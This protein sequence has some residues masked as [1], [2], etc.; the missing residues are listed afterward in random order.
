MKISKYTPP[1]SLLLLI[2]VTVTIYT[3]GSAGPFLFDDF[4]N[5][6]PMA[7]NGGV[8]DVGNGLA[9][10]FGSDGTELLRSV[11]RASF[12]LN[13][14][15]WPSLP[16][17][18]KNTNILLHLI[19]G[20][21]VVYLLLRLLPRHLNEREALV[22][23]LFCGAVWLL[24]PLHVSTV[25]YVVQRMT[26][27]MLMFVL[28]S[29][30]SYTYFRTESHR[31]RKFSWLMI[32]AITALLG[33][34]SKENAAVVLMLYWLVDVCFFRDEKERSS[35]FFR[36][37]P[38]LA[39]ALFVTVFAVMVFRTLSVYDARPF[40]MSERLLAQ[41]KVIADYLYFWFSP[42]SLALSLFHDDVLWKVQ[43]M[44][45]LKAL[46]YWVMHVVIVLGSI[47]LRKRYPIIFFGVTFFYISHVIEST[48]IPLELMFEHR[49]YLPS[50]G[51]ALVS[52]SVVLK[53]AQTIKRHG[54]PLASLV[55][56]MSLLAVLS[57]Y[58]AHR[59]A[60]WSDYRIMSSKWAA[61]HPHSLRA[62]IS[63]IS[64]LEL[65]RMGP[66]AADT[67][68]MVAP[69]FE[70]LA[71]PMYRLRLECEY[72]PPTERSVQVNVTEVSSMMFDSGV[73]HQLNALMGYPEKECIESQLVNGGVS[74]LVDA[75]GN[76][77][78]LAEK[79]SYYAQYLDAAADFYI[80]QRNYVKAIQLRE[81]LWL[82][83]PSVATALQFSELFILGGNL[84]QAKKYLMWAKEKHE[85]T[86]FGSSSVSRDIDRLQSIVSKLANGK[87]SG[88]E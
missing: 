53:F 38:Y 86:W 82:T 62:Q 79:K 41:G 49:N 46:L 26:Q 2:G 57:I 24:H 18:F 78:L 48:L 77:R 19:N 4:S 81:K 63:F 40:S 31:W 8:T 61:E 60:V 25:L 14:Q 83:Q 23:A 30:I 33:L 69:R 9:F 85:S 10:V 76:M 16:V 68:A 71:L 36:W 43:T 64:M 15:H 52:G 87:V 47:C 12:L 58:L 42:G 21:L 51:L 44:G 1:L 34:F 29:L 88:N 28:L 66:V 39:V 54:M 37:L 5:L 3:L 45:V 56:S 35:A 22:V 72:L 20:L 11:S 17:S 74:E 50:I 27:L 73:L 70:S 65:N 84:E 7:N 75:V 6:R 55:L 32:A 13:D 80:D 67:A 59:V